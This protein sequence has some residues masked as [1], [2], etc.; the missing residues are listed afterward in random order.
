MKKL[1]VVSATILS[2]WS[3]TKPSSQIV[4]D[5]QVTD[6]RNELLIEY[7]EAQKIIFEESVKRQKAK[8]IEF[9][10]YHFYKDRNYRLEFSPQNYDEGQWSILNDSLL[11]YNSSKYKTSDTSIIYFENGKNA[12]ISMSDAT[13]K[14]S[15]HISKK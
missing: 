3:C 8:M 7:P 1:I 9:A 14:I 12:V 10:A 15:V 11:I 13:Q 6:Y 5:W 4:G 2:L